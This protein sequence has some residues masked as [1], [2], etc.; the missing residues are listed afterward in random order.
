MIF[1]YMYHHDITDNDCYTYLHYINNL[2]LLTCN[3]KNIFLFFNKINV[4]FF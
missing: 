4:N 2:I 3:F 1:L